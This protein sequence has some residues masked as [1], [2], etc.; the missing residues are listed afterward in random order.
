[1]ELKKLPDPTKPEGK[2]SSGKGAAADLRGERPPLDL[3]DRP[4]PKDT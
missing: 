2:A 1:M 3:Y 4:Y